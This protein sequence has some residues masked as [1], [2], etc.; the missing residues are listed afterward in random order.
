VK[1]LGSILLEEGVLTEDQLMDAIDAQQQR[2]QSLGRTLV[3][4]GMISEAQLVK[5][6]ASQVGISGSV[7]L[8]RGVI[9]G[10]NVGVADHVEIGDG[11]IFGARSGISKS[12]D[13][14]KTYLDAPAVEISDARRRMVVYGRLPEIA[15]RLRK[16]EKK[17]EELES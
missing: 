8:G 12:L 10:G 17:I 1:Q 5:A 4:L 7:T 14:G 11:A 13:G 3:E 2:G 9:M 15:K 16:V 6:L